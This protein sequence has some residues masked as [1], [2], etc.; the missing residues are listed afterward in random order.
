MYAG[1]GIEGD[2][3]LESDQDCAANPGL[4]PS[5]PGRGRAPAVTRLPRTGSTVFEGGV[6]GKCYDRPFRRTT[7]RGL[8]RRRENLWGI[9]SD[10]WEH[11]PLDRLYCRSRRH[12]KNERRFH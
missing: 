1:R 11:L 2:R 4:F 3:H 6:S 10:N 8:V 7:W 9:T 12:E 5:L